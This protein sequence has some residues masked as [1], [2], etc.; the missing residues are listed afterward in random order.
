M[1]RIIKLTE[2][3]I[4]SNIKEIVLLKAKQDNL[5]SELADT[6]L[7]IKT[8]EID[9][10]ALEMELVQYVSSKTLSEFNKPAKYFNKCNVGL[11]S[12]LGD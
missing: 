7:R 1:D 11:D 5:I 3:I 10:N 12:S 9:N 2:E 6:H 8:A 4:E